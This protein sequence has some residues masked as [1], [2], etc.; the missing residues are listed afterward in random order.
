MAKLLTATLS[1]VWS[2]LEGEGSFQRKLEMTPSWHHKHKVFGLWE[3][4]LRSLPL[5]CPLQPDSSCSQRSLASPIHS[6]HLPEETISSATRDKASSV[7]EGWMCPMTFS[8]IKRTWKCRFLQQSQ[9][10]LV[11][12]Q[13]STSRN[14]VLQS[15]RPA[16]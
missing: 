1:K 16:G 10:C 12:P 15:I 2:I 5:T 13:K 8:L 9:G 11:P 6:S 3:I 7:P 4:L 14:L